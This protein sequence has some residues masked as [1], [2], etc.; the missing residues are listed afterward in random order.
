MS[1]SVHAS[2]QVKPIIE[3]LLLDITEY[4]MALTMI[5]VDMHF[6]F[7]PFRTVF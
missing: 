7:N 2:L 4:Y 5:D 6:L 3:T 1:F